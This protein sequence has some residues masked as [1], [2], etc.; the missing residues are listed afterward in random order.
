VSKIL[1]STTSHQRTNE[2]AIQLLALRRAHAQQQERRARPF[3]SSPRA[4]GE[5][6][7]TEAAGAEAETAASANTTDLTVWTPEDSC[8]RGRKARVQADASAAQPAAS[9]E[10]RPPPL[11][12]CRPPFRCA[13]ARRWFVRSHCLLHAPSRCAAVVLSL[14]GV[15]SLAWRE[16]K[17]N[18]RGRGHGLSVHPS[19]GR[20]AQWSGQGAPRRHTGTWMQRH[21]LDGG[22]VLPGDCISQ[23][24]ET[25]H[26][27]RH[28]HRLRL[29]QT[30]HGKIR[31]HQLKREGMNAANKSIA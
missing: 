5:P 30:A 8:L 15:G 13:H 27:R 7:G 23:S 31:T 1:R 18:R 25:Q 29:W 22:V 11:G 19:G 28:G 20:Q 4:W 2:H 9:E 16:P 12:L 24:P 10:A 6:S 3:V 17:R 26:Q 21:A 14:C